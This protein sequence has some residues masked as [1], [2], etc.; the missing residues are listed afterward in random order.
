MISWCSAFNIHVSKEAATAHESWS[1]KSQLRITTGTVGQ[2]NGLVQERRNS[3]ANTLEL[4]LSCTKLS[5]SSWHK[6]NLNFQII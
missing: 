5:K 4:R 3:T 2:I 6:Q 1:G